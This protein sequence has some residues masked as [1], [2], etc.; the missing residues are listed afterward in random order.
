MMV[1]WWFGC[2][3]ISPL[4]VS[5][6]ECLPIEYFSAHVYCFWCE[7]R[8]LILTCKKIRK[9][10]ENLINISRWSST[11]WI[12][13]EAVKSSWMINPRR[14]LFRQ[15]PFGLT[16]VHST[17]IAYNNAPLPSG[18]YNTKRIEMFE[19]SCY[20]FWK[21]KKKKTN[22]LISQRV[23]SAFSSTNCDSWQVNCFSL[24]YT[25]PSRGGKSL[26]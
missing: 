15:W 6:G 23:V 10:N 22:P 24:S 25:T 5:R 21:K 20:Y 11:I 4:W 26:F 2:G 7:L 1:V 9:K 19:D 17:L 3:G 18:W 14:I 13:N 16:A 12:L 8:M